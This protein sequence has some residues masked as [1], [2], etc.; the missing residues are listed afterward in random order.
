[1]LS[2][3]RSGPEIPTPSE[4]RSG[5]GARRPS[6]ARSGPGIRRPP[7]PRSGPGTRSPPEARSGPG[8]RRPSEARSGPGIRGPSEGVKPFETV[9][10]CGIVT[11][12]GTVAVPGMVPASNGFT[13]SGT[14]TLFDGLVRLDGMLPT[15]RPGGKSLVP[16]LSL[17]LPRFPSQGHTPQPLRHPRTHPESSSHPASSAFEP[18]PDIADRRGGESARSADIRARQ[19]GGSKGSPT[20]AHERGEADPQKNE[21]SGRTARR[22][23]VSGET[24]R[25]SAEQQ[26]DGDIQQAQHRTTSQWSEAAATAESN[27]S[28]ERPSGRSREQQ[29][30]GRT[31]R[32][33]QG[34]TSRRND[35][36]A[37]AGSNESAERPGA[38]H[39]ATNIQ[40]AQ[41]R[42]PGQR[43]PPPSSAAA[44]ATQARHRTTG[45]A[46]RPGT[47]GRSR[48]RR[49]GGEPAAKRGGRAG[50][51]AAGRCGAYA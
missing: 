12:P 32:P 40:Q 38:R 7:E 28:A 43:R 39:G 44:A 48:E 47:A 37:T 29:V 11:L 24:R 21:R 16:A 46:E 51:G 10:V 27:K 49:V 3:A 36:A 23:R 30:S 31:R 2:E 34:A 14:M 8:A 50:G 9:P 42:A 17:A 25:G 26:A 6:E 18:L 1:M 15:V 22:Q 41:H 20:R 35:L 45:L 19:T 13:L 33:Q 4:A 5:P